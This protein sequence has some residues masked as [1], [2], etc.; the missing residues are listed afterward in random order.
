LA[1]GNDHENVKG[2]VAPLG[3]FLKSP[4]S[5]LDPGGT[6]RL[7]PIDA[8]ISITKRSSPL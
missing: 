4:S 5:I 2:Q 1:S 6:V 7:P 3:L 8:V